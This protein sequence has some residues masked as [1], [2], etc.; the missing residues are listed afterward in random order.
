MT[1]NDTTR[2]AVMLAITNALTVAVLFG[3]SMSDIQVTAL[4]SFIN[5]GMIVGMLLFKKGQ[6]AG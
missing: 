1:F 6:E 5:S 2:A 4:E 3:V